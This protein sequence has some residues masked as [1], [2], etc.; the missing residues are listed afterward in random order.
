MVR[1]R[2]RKRYRSA[3]VNVVGGYRLTVTPWLGLTRFCATDVSLA[4]FWPNA[5]PKCIGRPLFV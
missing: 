5:V 3:R 4:P 2:G 1:M